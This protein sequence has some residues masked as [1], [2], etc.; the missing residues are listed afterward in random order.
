MLVPFITLAVAVFALILSLHAN[1]V[2]QRHIDTLKK[3]SEELSDDCNRALSVRYNALVDALKKDVEAYLN[4]VSDSAP[5]EDLS[6]V[7]QYVEEN[8]VKINE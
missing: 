2:S 4:P 3:W 6:D 5:Y 8:D 7:E 1:V